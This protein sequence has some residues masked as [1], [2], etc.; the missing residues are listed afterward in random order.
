MSH[1]AEPLF[2]RRVPGPV[3]SSPLLVDANEDG[4]PEVFVGGPVLSGLTWRGERLPRWPKR[5]RKPFASSPAFGDIN[6]DGRGEIVVGCDDGKVHAF[7]VDGDCVPGWPVQTGR[8]V[9][10]TPALADIDGDGM[11]EVLVGSDDGCVYAV[12]GNGEKRWVGRIPGAPFVSASPTVIDLDEDGRP[13]V[14]VG[15]WDRT[16]RRFSAD[17]ES[18]G[19]WSLPAG[20]ML[21]SSPTA[22]EVQGVGRVVAWASDRVYLARAGG[23]IVEGWPRR[24]GSWTVSSPAVAEIAKGDGPV[25]AV[26]SERLYAW[27][28]SGQ[29]LPGF[30]VDTGDF[31]WSSPILVDIDGDEKREI[32]VGTWDGGLYAFRTDGTAVQGFPMRMNGPVFSTAAA[33]ALPE[34]GGLLVTAAWDGTIRGWRL[35]RA[36]FRKGDW[37]QFRG[38]PSRSGVHPYPFRAD[39]RTPAPVDPD[40]HESPTISRVYI[41]RWRVGRGLPRVVIEG[42]GLA[43]AR[44]L[45]V[46]YKIAGE[47]R[48]HPVPAVNSRG[49]FVALIQPLRGPRLIQGLVEMEDA[50][51]G[52][53]RWPASGSFSFVAGPMA[54][55]FVV[56]LSRG[57]RRAAGRRFATNGDKHERPDILPP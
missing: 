24:T 1:L 4:W 57:R 20:S 43:A 30:P 49:R 13:E 52:M 10:S 14:L 9:F 21:W 18:L 44:S 53:H 56:T 45:L 17:G 35:P 27:S 19:E 34:G 41:E 46:R 54:P 23:Q 32:V 42:S 3:S 51:G 12:G 25:I 40:P 15:A 2:I 31:V 55:P 47:G 5:S 29:R 39:Q 48:T 36:I 7:F 28:L 22:F 50:Q 8:D 38:N 26:G 33:C 6:G 11:P 16:L 37:P